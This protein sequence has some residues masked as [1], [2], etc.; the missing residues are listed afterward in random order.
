LNR[1]TPVPDERD[2]ASI[3]SE[4]VG[5]RTRG[6]HLTLEEDGDDLL[7]PLDEAFDRSTT[8]SRMGDDSPPRVS[9]IGGFDDVDRVDDMDDMDGMDVGV[10]SGGMKDS[11]KDREKRGG[12]DK[13]RDGTRESGKQH[14]PQQRVRFHPPRDSLGS[15]SWVETESVILDEGDAMG[16]RLGLEEE[17]KRIPS[18]SEDKERRRSE[19]ADGGDSS[20]HPPRL[21]MARGSSDVD[22]EAGTTWQG[23]EE[24]R[25]DTPVEMTKEDERDVKTWMK[26]LD[27]KVEMFVN[28]GRAEFVIM[29]GSV[30]RSKAREMQPESPSNDRERERS[31]VAS[32]TLS[33]SSVN[34]VPGEDRKNLR[35]VGLS[36][37]EIKIMRKERRKIFG[38]P[39][40]GNS[41]KTTHKSPF[42]ESLEV[43]TNKLTFN[44]CVISFLIGIMVGG[45]YECVYECVCVCCR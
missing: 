45:M 28:R 31:D 10:V 11:S 18:S 21:G 5:S 25:I 3:L 43:C 22:L 38:I 30:S 4:K 44:E 36:P 19:A 35:L 1:T 26:D 37:L 16:A 13:E 33:T 41:W 32:T 15:V 39:I 20:T 12:G 23:Q 24:K 7:E 9:A 8:S 29:S 17:G 6:A 42:N 2:P 34:P 40:G 14:Q 27:R